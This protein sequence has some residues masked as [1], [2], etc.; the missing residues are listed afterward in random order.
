MGEATQNQLF[1]TRLDGVCD[2]DG[3]L[4]LESNPLKSNGILTFDIVS[5]KTPTANAIVA[6]EFVKGPLIYGVRTVKMATADFWYK[7]RGPVCVPSD[8]SVR[9]TYSDAGNAKYCEASIYGKLD[10]CPE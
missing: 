9:L 10:V 7:T 3:D 4:V 6:I 1:L 5:T 8:W 2:A